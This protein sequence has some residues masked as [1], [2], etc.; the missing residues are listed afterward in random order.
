MAKAYTNPDGHG[1][2]T[3]WFKLAF[4]DSTNIWKDSAGS[5][6]WVANNID[7]TDM[8]MDTPSNNFATLN[9]L[10][11]NSIYSGHVAN[12]ISEWNLKQNTAT[13][14]A[15]V[16]NQVIKDYKV[17]W[18]VKV[19][20][21][22]QCQWIVSAWTTWWVTYSYNDPTAYGYYFRWNKI[23]AWVWW[24]T[25]YDTTANVIYMFA[26]D[27]INWKMWVWR[28][29]VWTWDPEAWTWNEFTLPENKDWWTT[30]WH[31]A[32]TSQNN[33][34]WYNFWQGWLAW[35]TYYPEAWGSFKYAPPAGFKALST[36]NMPEP[37]IV[38]P[39]KHFGVATYTWEWS[40]QNITWLWFMPDLSWVKNRTNT[41]N[42]QLHNSVV[43]PDKAVFSNLTNAEWTSVNM[44]TSF[45]TDWFTISWSSWNLNSLWDNYVSWNWKAGWTAVTNNDWSITSQ[46]SANVDAGFS[47][48]GYTGNWIVWATV[49]HWLNKEPELVI[50][51]NRNTDWQWN[52]ISPKILWNWYWLGFNT[53]VSS[54]YNS[55]WSTDTNNIILAWWAGHNSLNKNY[56]TYAFHSVPGYSKVWTYTGNWSD[57]GVFVYTGFKPR[58]IMR[59]RIDS[60]YNW[61]IIDSERSKNNI[62]NEALFADLSFAEQVDNTN[63]WVDLLSNWFKVRNI[64]ANVLWWKYIYIAFAEAPF[65]YANAR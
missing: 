14:S 21:T 53:N 27:P 16:S 28:D 10:F 57:D 8:V 58:Y 43:W 34:A 30:W 40:T 41:S 12:S 49:G 29:G 24:A 22:N 62:T 64:W 33:H 65:K 15:Y 38:D 51:K 17:Y 7:A 25:T 60:T 18:E 9:P 37:S 61:W 13:H 56:I 46:V 31:P 4:D 36:G 6:D 20:D 26:V 55:T 11:S 54:L 3:N 42:H 63:W 2:G 50:S 39:S 45:N 35:V 32:A 19:E 23:E 5:N 47:I 1:Y 52:I 44:I 59:K 48:V